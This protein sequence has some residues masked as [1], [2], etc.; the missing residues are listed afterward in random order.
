V[1]IQAFEFHSAGAQ[2]VTFG[3]TQ[4]SGKRLMRF[5]QGARRDLRVGGSDTQRKRHKT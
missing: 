2:I 5:R 4:H 3:A 1:A